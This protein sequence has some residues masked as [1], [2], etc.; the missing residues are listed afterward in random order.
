MRLVARLLARRVGAARARLVAGDLAQDVVVAGFVLVFGLVVTGEYVVFERGLEALV[1]LR[2]AGTA[3]SLYVLE[4]VMVLILIISLVSYVASGLWIHFRAG[5]TRLLLA[6]PLPLG[7]LYGLRSLETFL[8]TS[9]ALAIVGLPALAALGVAHGV[10]PAFYAIGVGVLLLFAVLVGAAGTVLTAVAGALLRGAPT[11]R[12]VVI[13]VAALL[14]V[15]AALVGRNVVPSTGDF[16]TIFE[17]GLHNGKTASVKFI[18]TKFALWPSHPFAAALH[19]AATGSHAGSTATRVMLWLAPAGMLVLAA[20]AGRALYRRAL[21]AIAES[22]VV[23]GGGGAVSLRAREFPRRLRGPIGAL[24]ERALL[25]LVR[26]PH[27]WSRAAFLGFLLLLYTSFVFVAP[28]GAVADR[29]AAV[30]RLLLLNVLASGYFVTAFG[31]RFVFPSV[32]LEGRAAWVLFSSPVDLGR[33]LLAKLALY[34]GLLT[35]AV[36]PIALAGTLRLV[37]DPTLVGATAT[38]LVTLVVTTATLSL[39]FGAAWPDFREPNPESLSTSG[40]GLLLTLV[41]LAYVGLVGWGARGAAL[42]RSGGGSATPWLTVVLAISGL[43]IAGALRVA[44]R[45]LRAL[46]TA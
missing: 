36:V 30:A 34:A 26:N 6:A 5:D 40:G 17:P 9:W 38:L 43:L 8:L 45:R 25:A 39:A 10:G 22:F 31:L 1:P 37:G 2:L 42:A 29:P 21:P 32:S 7:A 28:L 12:A 33:L 15:F 19:D 23:S 3:L 41:C 11:R 20:T 24:V 14:T 4:S 18:E 27:E 35:A 16:Y 13:T 44:T 46:E